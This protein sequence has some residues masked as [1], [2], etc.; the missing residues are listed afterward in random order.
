MTSPV[1]ERMSLVIARCYADARPS[2]LS[3]TTAINVLKALEENITD[4]MI[5][6][7]V[8]ALSNNGV[9]EANTDDAKECFT[10]MLRAARG[11]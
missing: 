5:L 7:G 2:I 9:D 3:K 6:H 11:E 1:I 8:M 4:E 10:A